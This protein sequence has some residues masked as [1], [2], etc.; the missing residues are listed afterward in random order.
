M[1]ITRHVPCVGA[2]PELQIGEDKGKEYFEVREP[3]GRTPIRYMLW[4]F[5]S[6]RNNQKREGRTTLAQDTD[7]FQGHISESQMRLNQL[8][9]LIIWSTRRILWCRR[10]QE[11]LRLLEMHLT[12]PWKWF[13]L[14]LL[15]PKLQELFETK[16]KKEGYVAIIKPSVQ[17]DGDSKDL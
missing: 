8:F 2:P 5:S 9:L 3:L 6:T 14:S 1:S 17:P 7:T 12:L 4:C 10:L 13:N 16:Q 11:R 15:S